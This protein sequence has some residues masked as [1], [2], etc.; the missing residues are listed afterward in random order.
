MYSIFPYMLQLTWFYKKKQTFRNFY[1]TCFKNKEITYKGDLKVRILLEYSE[2]GCHLV[3][4]PCTLVSVYQ[5]LRDP[6]C[7]QHQCSLFMEAASTSKTSVNSYQSTRSY[8]TKYIHFR[9]NHREN[10]KHYL[11]YFR[12][13]I[14]NTAEAWSFCGSR[15][16]C[17]MLR[18]RFSCNL[19]VQSARCAK[20]TAPL[21]LSASVSFVI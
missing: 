7:V 11:G 16:D 5:R 12:C 10:L 8:K 21:K 6:H 19:P 17:D 18:A 14:G 9:T 1:T 13:V 20:M 4:A 2:N 15:S 3:V